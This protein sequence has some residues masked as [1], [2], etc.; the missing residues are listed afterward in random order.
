MSHWRILRTSGA[1]ISVSS[2]RSGLTVPGEGVA[3]TNMSSWSLGGSGTALRAELEGDLVRLAA[4]DLLGT[5]GLLGALDLL[6]ALAAGVLDALESLVAMA[7]GAEGC[8]E[9]GFG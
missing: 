5:F 4:L 8:N 7:I 6:E 3:G 1:S 2:M 9:C